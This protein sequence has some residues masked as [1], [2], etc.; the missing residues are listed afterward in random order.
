MTVRSGFLGLAALAGVACSQGESGGAAAVSPEVARGRQIYQ[1]TCIACH[2]SDPNQAGALGP[3][4]AGASIELLEAKVLRNEYPPG[5]TPKRE[6][7]AM[8]PMPHLASDIPALHAYLASVA[9]GS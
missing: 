1:T 5:Y 7:R 4:I 8:V 6:S 3:P 9:K 2:A